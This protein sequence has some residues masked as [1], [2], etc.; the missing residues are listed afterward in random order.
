MTILSAE[1]RI[2]TASAS[3]YLAQLLKHAAAMGGGAGHRI[4]RHRPV[5]DEVRVTIE[6]SDSEGVI[7]FGAWGRCVVRAETEALTAR[8]DGAD[9]DKLARIQGII[10]RNLDRYARREGTSVDWQRIQTTDTTPVPGIAAGTPRTH[11]RRFLAVALPAIVAAVALAI[12]LGL[13][14]AALTNENWTRSAIGLVLVVVLVK[15]AVVI[16]GFVFRRK[17]SQP[18]G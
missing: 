15:A 17:R 9:E 13:G 4:G 8:V 12:H 7:T 11:R 18:S 10:G 14:A 16:G 5:T 2:E 6:S 1:A 3:K